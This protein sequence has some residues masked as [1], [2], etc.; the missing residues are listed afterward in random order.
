MQESFRRYQLNKRTTAIVESRHPWVYSGQVSSAAG[1]F[2]D[3][4]WIKLF[5]GQNEVLGFGIYS[6]SDR[7]AIRMLHFG[8][9]LRNRFFFK[10]LR[11][12]VHRRFNLLPTTNGIRL[13]HG[14]SDGWPGVTAD[15]YDGTVV[16]LYYS[17]SLQKLARL[18]SLLLPHVEPALNIKNIVVRPATRSGADMVHKARV[19]RGEIPREAIIEENGLKLAVDL[20]KGQKGG[21]F[22]DLRPSRNL[23]RELPLEGKKVLNLFCSTGAF[24]IL[25]EKQGAS[26][27]VSVDQAPAA[28]QSVK[29]NLELNGCDAAKHETVVADAFHWLSDAISRGDR[30]DFIMIDPP[31]MASKQDQIPLA[32]KKHKELHEKALSLLNPGGAWLTCCCTARISDE[33]LIPIVGR[34]AKEYFGKGVVKLER[35]LKPDV[36]HPELRAFPEG[37]YLKQLFF[38][39]AMPV[40]E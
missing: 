39:T 37:H 38:T 28:I 26:H 2:R 15:L 31:C 20:Q 9:Q 14:E 16:I 3:G 24:S 33:D 36:D 21:M 7:Q 22:L 13:I 25:C 19:T 27:I 30:F 40:E 4:E 29:R 32:L 34:A 35:N 12:I 10:R 1:A 11:D 23:I 17:T 6:A 8:P 5:D 18:T